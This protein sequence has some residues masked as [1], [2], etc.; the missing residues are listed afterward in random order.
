MSSN[1]VKSGLKGASRAV[2]RARP[3]SAFMRLHKTSQGWLGVAGGAVMLLALAPAAAPAAH[4]GPTASLTPSVAVVAPGDSVQF[5]GRIC[6]PHSSLPAGS[7]GHLEHYRDGGFEPVAPVAIV[8]GSGPCSGY[9]TSLSVTGEGWFR[10]RVVGGPG[11]AATTPVLSSMAVVS[12]STPG[13]P[14]PEGD[15][16]EDG[17]RG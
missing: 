2:R 4:A 13:P 7:V 11:A 8:P 10:V 14:G 3:H 5:S 15:D 1:L 16:G 9:S 6:L 12:F 17:D